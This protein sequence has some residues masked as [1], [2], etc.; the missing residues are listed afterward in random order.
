MSEMIERVAEAIYAVWARNN[1]VFAPWE[2][3]VRLH[4]SVVDEARQE[5]EA[6][7]EAMREPSDEMMVAAEMVVPELSTFA[8]KEASPSYNAYRAMITEA[9]KETP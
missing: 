2:E 9:L 4:H 1:D 5:A 3:C 6:A 8:A 7:I